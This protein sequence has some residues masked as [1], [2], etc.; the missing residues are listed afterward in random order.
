MKKKAFRCPFVKCKYK[1][2]SLIK[3][4]EHLVKIHKY[5]DGKMRDKLGS[6]GK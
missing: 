5:G 4:N 6:M 3:I 1:S 2:N